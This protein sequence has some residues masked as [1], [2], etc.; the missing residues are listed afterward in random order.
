MTARIPNF[1]T[2]S[3]IIDRLSIENVK[4]SHFEFLLTQPNQDESNLQE[5]ISLQVEVIKLLKREL[6]EFMFEAFSSKDYSYIDE[7]RT[8]K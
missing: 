4:L 3:T 8:F 5:K 7:E 6:E 1:N 2:F